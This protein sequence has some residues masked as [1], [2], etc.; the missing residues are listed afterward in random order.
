M[1]ADDV[2]YYVSEINCEGLMEGYYWQI[3]EAMSDKE[4]V[5][6]VI[7][8]QELGSSRGRVSEMVRYQLRKLI[9]AELVEVLDIDTYSSEYCDLNEMLLLDIYL[10]ANVIEDV[11]KDGS[12][13]PTE[14]LA[15]QQ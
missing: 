6:V 10:N 5:T 4:D 15:L 14:I 13:Y 3:M 8:L 7:Q 11:V 2:V 1:W 12:L 9:L